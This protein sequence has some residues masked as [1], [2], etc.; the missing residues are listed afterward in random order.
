[1]VPMTAALAARKSR[2][3]VRRMVSEPL[4]DA[5]RLV[6]HVRK[7]DIGAHER[8]IDIGSATG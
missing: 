3:L 2:R 7:P 6:Q 5:S 8:Q 1:M 4:G